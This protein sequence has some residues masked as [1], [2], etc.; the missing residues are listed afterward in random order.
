MKTNTTVKSHVQNWTEM[1]GKSRITFYR[2]K[3][4][5]SEEVM[6]SIA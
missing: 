2:K 1:T 6:V 4:M 3:K 5:L